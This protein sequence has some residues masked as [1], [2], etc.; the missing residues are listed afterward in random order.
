MVSY[1]FGAAG[2]GQSSTHT[3][4][5]VEGIAPENGDFQVRNLLF[6]GVE[7]FRFLVKYVKLFRGVPQNDANINSSNQLN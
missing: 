3:T 7:F 2:F 6:L 1:I 4:P 5:K